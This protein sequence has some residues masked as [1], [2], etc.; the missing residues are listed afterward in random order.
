MASQQIEAPFAVQFGA[1]GV[2]QH[3]QETLINMYAEQPVGG[4][5]QLLRRQRPGLRRVLAL[6]GEKRCIEYH[7][8]TYYLVVGATLYSFDGAS[9]T[10]LGTLGTSTGRCTMI[11]NDNDQIMVSDG[12]TGYYY[13]SGTL[14]VTTLPDGVTCGTLAYLGGYGVFNDAGTGQ[15][16]WTGLNDFSTVDALDFATAERA[17][18]AIE[19]VYVDHNE[20]WLFGA[21]TTEVWQL[22]GG[23]DSPFTPLGNAQLER[24][25]AAS[26]SVASEDNTVFFLGEDGIVYRADGY[27]PMRVSTHA[28]ESA[29]NDIPKSEWADAYAMVYTTR[30]HKFYTL[31]FPGRA[32]F[33]YNMATGFWNRA[34]TFGYDDWKVVGSAGHE[35]DYVLTTGGICELVAGLS[36]DESGILYRGGIG[37]PGW[38]GGNNIAVRSF[39]LDA[40]VGE[41]GQ[42]VDA[43]VMLRVARDGVSFGNELWRSLGETGD[44]ARRT[45]WRNLGMGRKPVVQFGITDPVELTVIGVSA[46]VEV[47][48]A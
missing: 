5:T 7:N 1:A 32:T 46:E 22:S 45:V 39:F 15:F 41:A 23:S 34:K 35:S 31:T 19:R 47:L 17:P 25:L 42:G 28:I 20:L 43:N 48:R 40:E 26:Y 12:T 18:D 24:G 37:A 44:Y 3:T 13:D 2:A 30:G 11:F 21:A 16:Y 14:A 36:T 33:Q 10:T 6:S 27:R 29:I 38:A 4:R 8:G 9:T